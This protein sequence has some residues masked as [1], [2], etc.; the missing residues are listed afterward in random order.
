MFRQELQKFNAGITWQQ[1]AT[2]LLVPLLENGGET[3]LDD[4]LRTYLEPFA[5]MESSHSRL[6]A[7][8]SAQAARASHI[9]EGR[10]YPWPR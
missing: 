5:D 10:G 2:P 7:L 4:V 8:P 1:A 6:Y 9:R 3:W